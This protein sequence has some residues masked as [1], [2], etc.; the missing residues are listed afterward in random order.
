[1]L[2]PDKN[3]IDALIDRARAVSGIKRAE[4]D[5]RIKLNKE[6]E[7]KLKSRLTTASGELK[8]AC[9]Q[10]YSKVAYPKGAEPRLD[11]ISTLTETKQNN[12]TAMIIELLNNK[13]KLLAPEK[14][15]SHEIIPVE[16]VTSITKILEN[17]KIDK[18]KHFILEPQQIFNAAGD[19]VKAGAFGYSEEAPEQQDGKYVGKIEEVVI[20]SWS[21]FLIPKELVVG[22]KP[23]PGP[24]VEPLIPSNFRY[25]I[26]ASDVEKILEVL[27]QLSIL[28]L[29]AQLQKNLHVTLEFK[30]TSISIT[31]KLDDTEEMKSLLNILKS[32]GFSGKGLF[33]ISSDTDV[34]KDLKNWEDD[35]EQE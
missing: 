12:L 1:M 33:T 21:G 31:S 4:K 25:K 22:A 10:V 16:K 24:R 29:D 17:F 18:S 28:S 32:R 19:G 2:Y 26:R 34:S 15:L 8:T 3:G 35:F 23:K 13:G 14:E 9:I 11:Q 5:E 7:T 20:A 27:S 6:N 30:D